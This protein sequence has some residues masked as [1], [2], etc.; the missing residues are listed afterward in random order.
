MAIGYNDQVVRRL[1]AAVTVEKYDVV[2]MSTT[3]GYVAVAGSGEKAVGIAKEDANPGDALDV[4]IEGEYFAYASAAIAVGATVAA[5]ATGQIRTAIS[6]DATIVGHMGLA[7]A[8]AVTNDLAA[9]RIATNVVSI[10]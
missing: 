8:A 4:V 6:T 2:K 9:V 10:A 1:L 5:G 7:Q 3:T